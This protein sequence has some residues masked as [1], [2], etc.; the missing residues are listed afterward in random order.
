MGVADLRNTHVAEICS[1]GLR[2]MIQSGFQGRRDVRG[3]MVPNLEWANEESW[4]RLNTLSFGSLMAYT[5]RS[6]CI[7]AGLDKE[8]IIKK[9]ATDFF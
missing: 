1:L 4:I 9:L 6:A 7:L 3:R 8:V 2:D 5:F